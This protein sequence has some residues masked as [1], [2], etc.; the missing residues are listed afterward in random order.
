LSLLNI[1]GHS[2]LSR[3]LGKGCIE[4]DGDREMRRIVF[5]VALCAGLLFSG[6]TNASA[7]IYCS[8]DP[9]YNVGLPISYSL[10]VSLKTPLLSTHVYVSG[11]RKTTTWGGGLGIL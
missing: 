7:A 6:I 4:T 10:D 8:A 9:T 1:E 3:S 11:T 2:L 5:G